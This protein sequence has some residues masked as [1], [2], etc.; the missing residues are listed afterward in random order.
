M[1]NLFSLTEGRK[2]DV[3]EL[4][5]V[6]DVETFEVKIDGVGPYIGR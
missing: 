4:S 5:Y 3:C 2:V 1:G 6:G